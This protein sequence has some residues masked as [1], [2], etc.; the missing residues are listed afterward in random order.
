MPEIIGYGWHIICK[1][2][3]KE[4]PQVNSLALLSQLNTM[5]VF[6]TNRLT[7]T[8][9]DEHICNQSDMWPHVNSTAQ[10]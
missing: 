8:R 2:T 3:V 7:E 10:P 4:F 9:Y 6:E 5:I 1:F